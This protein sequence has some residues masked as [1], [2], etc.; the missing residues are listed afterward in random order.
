LA[1][2]TDEELDSV[3]DVGDEPVRLIALSGRR[4]QLAV[5]V[6]QI[7]SRLTD[8]VVPPLQPMAQRPAVEAQP[9]VQIR[10]GTV[11][12]TRRNGRTSDSA[13][14]CVRQSAAR[15]PARRPAA[16]RRMSCSAR[17]WPVTPWAEIGP[18]QA[19]HYCIQVRLD[20]LDAVNPDNNVGG[21]NTIVAEANSPVRTTAS[22]SPGRAR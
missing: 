5:P 2:V 18:S 13:A 11:A 3:L 1:A 14:G 9:G 17:R 21:E 12:S 4:H 20:W 19:G 15:A 22:R 16:E 8:R 7:Q 6:G 10:T